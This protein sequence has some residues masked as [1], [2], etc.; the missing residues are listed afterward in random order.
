MKNKVVIDKEGKLVA[1]VGVF[2]TVGFTHRKNLTVRKTPTVATRSTQS[3][4]TPERQ[5]EPARPFGHK[6]PNEAVNL[7]KIKIAHFTKFRKAVNL[8][9]IPPLAHLKPSTD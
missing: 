2:P 5:G 7:L 6:R 8:L 4:C 1:T 9:K 3:D